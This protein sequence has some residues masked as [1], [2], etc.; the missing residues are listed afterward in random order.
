MVAGGA[1]YLCHLEERSGEESQ[2][3]GGDARSEVRFFVDGAAAG[4]T[5]G[6]VAGAIQSVRGR[7]GGLRGEGKYGLFSS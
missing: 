7:I 2:G 4:S 6:L 1:A 5:G 3:D